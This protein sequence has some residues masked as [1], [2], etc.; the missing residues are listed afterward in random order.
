M[1]FLTL[2]DVSKSFGDLHAVTGLNL[3]VE[4]GEF[5][6]LLGP[7][8]C[9]KTTTL[10]MI[11]GFIETSRGRITL[12]GRDIT[13]MKPNRRGLGIVFQSYALF[14]HMSVAQ[15]VSFG[16]EM[17]GVDKAERADRVR[18]VLALVRLDALA[19]RFPRELSGGQRQRVA[20]AR[21]IVIAPP[22][23]LLDEPMS[24]LDAKLREDMQ[25]ELR[26]IQ[27]KIGTTTIM[28]TH[29]QSEALSISD[30][31]VVMEAGR[32][33]QIDTPYRAYERPENLFVSQF[34]GKANMLAGKVVSRDGDAIRIDFGHDLAQTGSLAQLA[35]QGQSISVG[36]AVTLCIRPEKLRLCAPDKGRLAGNVTSR[37]FLG[38]QW[39]YRLD[40]RV[41]EMLV[42]CQ[43]H[44]DEPFPEGAQVGID[45]H[46]DSLRLIGRE[47]A[48]G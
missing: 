17:R 11:A 33:T 18:E 22:V 2:T 12:D 26:A 43:N 13:H 9:G 48:H 14:P 20:I 36:D 30:R 34:I 27:R 6:S 16:L 4:K 32:I 19:H 28:V 23:L 24:N 21:A 38:S 42:C 1:S 46:A 41:G 37:F 25:F 15:N 31:V 5:V 10:Q 35:S 40:S 47:R 29:D 44:G 8:G 39:L 7:S 3:S 45:W